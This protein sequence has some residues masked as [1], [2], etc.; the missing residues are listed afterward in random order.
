MPPIS[1]GVWVLAIPNGCASATSIA[2]STRS[3]QTMKSA[4]CARAERRP[5]DV[6][7]GIPRTRTPPPRN[8]Q[9]R[10]SRTLHQDLIGE[11]R[12]PSHRRIGLVS[13]NFAELL[14]FRKGHLAR[15]FR[16]KLA[17][18]GR[19]DQLHRRLLVEREVDENR[20]IVDV[21]FQFLR[22][23]RRLER[24]GEVQR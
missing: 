10:L 9:A 11:L 17:W 6:M 3:M 15:E 7:S 24:Q 12:A 23:H 16:V 13:G 5:D 14:A 1:G 19:A 2:P 8:A 21:D 18:R 22:L 4:H 20:R